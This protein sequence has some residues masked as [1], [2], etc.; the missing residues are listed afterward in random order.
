MVAF[1]CFQ[2]VTIQLE[3]GGTVIPVQAVLGAE[4]HETVTVLQNHFDIACRETIFSVDMCERVIALSPE[5]EITNYQGD[6]QEGEK[7]LFHVSRMLDVR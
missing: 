6:K 3:N 5:R 1:T 7:I 4:P 2:V